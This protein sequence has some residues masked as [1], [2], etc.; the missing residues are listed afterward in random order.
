MG[1]GRATIIAFNRPNRPGNPRSAHAR[2]RGREAAC[3]LPTIRRGLYMSCGRCTDWHGNCSS[4]RECSF[5]SGGNTMTSQRTEGEGKAKTHTHPAVTHAHD[6]Y[7]V[8]HHH[9]GGLG[10][11]FEHRT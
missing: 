11:D 7:H 6:H 3:P 2:L 10:D 9:K 5:K 8:S 1:I 4:V